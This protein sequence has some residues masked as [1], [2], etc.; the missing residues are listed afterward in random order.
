M[1]QVNLV[2]QVRWLVLH[3]GLGITVHLFLVLQLVC[4]ISVLKE[5][6]LQQDPINAMIVQQGMLAQTTKRR[7]LQQMHK[8]K[9]H[10]QAIK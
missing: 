2:C 3:A 6:G 10:V 7:N 5:S 4:L 1:N 9:L 8:L